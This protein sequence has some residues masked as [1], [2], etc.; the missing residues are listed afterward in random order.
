MNLFLQ[1]G[2]NFSALEELGKNFLGIID[3]L[4]G[5]LLLLI[6]G[7]IIARIVTKILRKIL[8]KIG[9]DKLADRLNE[10]DLFYKN[11]IKITPSK[12]IPKVLYY[13]LIFIFTIA[14]TDVLG[15]AVISNLMSELLNYIPNAIAA[16]IVLVIGLVVADLLKNLIKT[17]CESL[18]I[19]AAGVIST[20][21][22][23]FVFINIIMM[24]LKQGNIETDFIEQNISIILAG[25]IGAFAIGYGMASRGLVA[26]FL[27]S[28]YNKE[29]I[30]IGDM[31][32]IDGVKGEV[33]A[34]DNLSVTLRMGNTK[35]I[36]PLSK[37]T[38]ESLSIH[39]E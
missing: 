35:T 19:P 39:E 13:I 23:Y 15:M 5:A 18:G 14:A 8:E 36:V 30:A 9:I 7:F 34:I 12:L 2:G 28:F 10:I 20:A 32:T 17:T 4:V 38:T 33:I 16:F 29:K 6:I 1:T 25:I 24:A 3:N 11:N 22:F 21:V 26:N 27:S 37:L 31:I